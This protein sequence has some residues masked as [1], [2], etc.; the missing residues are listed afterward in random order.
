MNIYRSI[1]SHI[2][3]PAPCLVNEV[4]G[5]LAKITLHFLPGDVLKWNVIDLCN[6][7]SLFS[8]HRFVVVVF[9]AFLVSALTLSTRRCLK[10]LL[11]R[12]G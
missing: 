7:S 5:S 4:A 10:C 11:I 2:A 6:R 12:L 3:T 1:V 9:W 8:R